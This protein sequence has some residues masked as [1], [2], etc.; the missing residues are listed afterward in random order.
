LAGKISVCMICYNHAKYVAKAIGSVLAQ[1]GPF[2]IELVIGDDCSTDGSREIVERYA[3]EFP[4]RVR[5][6][7][8]PTNLGLSRNFR[9]V[10]ERCDG[11]FIAIL[12][13]DD[14]WL[15]RHKLARQ[16]EFLD[17]H[18]ECIGCGHR[19]HRV[20][21]E[22]RI[23]DD[24]AVPSAAAVGMETFERI[25]LRN[26]FA[27]CSMVYRRGLTSLPAWMDTA[28]CGDWPLHL[29][30]A[31]KGPIGLLPD[32]L[33]AYRIHAAGTWSQLADVP[34]YERAL[35]LL[36]TLREHFGVDRAGPLDT[37][38]ASHWS[39]MI[40]LLAQG[41]QRRRAAKELRQLMSEPALRRRVRFSHLAGIGVAWCCPP[42][43]RVLARP[44]EAWNK[45][46]RL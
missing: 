8:T 29:L 6:L 34:R 2:Q 10:F 18:P 46:R 37:S 24:G 19:V 25:A 5:V 38:I 30:H 42:L 20:D 44:I 36:R 39:Y 4:D 32:V 45:K 41:G 9:R 28:S 13:G 43:V 7:P 33:G 31:D 17:A 27:T 11:D 23:L 14:Y 26:P 12:E 3:R 1:E 21:E 15:T 22:D 35:P 40:Y 16:L